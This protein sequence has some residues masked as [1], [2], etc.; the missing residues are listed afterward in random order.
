MQK[1]K[2]TKCNLFPLLSCEIIRRHEGSIAC[3]LPH[4]VNSQGKEH[5]PVK[6]IVQ[7]AHTDGRLINI[8]QWRDQRFSLGGREHIS[9]TDYMTS[10]IQYVSLFP[11]QNIIQRKSL[12]DVQSPLSLQTQNFDARSTP[13]K[14]SGWEEQVD[15]MW[16]SDVRKKQ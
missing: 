8:L 15:L 9:C 14:G 5:A 3:V 11:H 6:R 4:L 2:S 7:N 10:I 16:I 1:T 12:N 13:G